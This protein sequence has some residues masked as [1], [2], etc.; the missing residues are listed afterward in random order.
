MSWSVKTYSDRGY[1]TIRRRSFTTFADG[2]EEEGEKVENICEHCVDSICSVARRIFI[3][4][5]VQFL[6]CREGYVE[7][8]FGRV[9]ASDPEWGVEGEFGERGGMSRKE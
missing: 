1:L 5:F 8:R 3:P 9:E 2:E 6:H 4:D 7:V